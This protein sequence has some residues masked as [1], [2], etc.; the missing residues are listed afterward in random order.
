MAL[1]VYVK[2]NIFYLVDTL[3]NNK[4]YE[5]HAKDA[6]VKRETTTATDFRFKNIEDWS[7]GKVVAFADIQ[8]ES[9]A[10][11]ADLATFVTFYEENTGKSSPGA[12]GGSELQIYEKIFWVDSAN[13]TFWSAISSSSVGE[14]YASTTGIDK[15]LSN[16]TMTQTNIRFLRHAGVATANQ[17]IV[18]MDFML[19][20]GGDD[21]SGISVIKANFSNNHL[22]LDSVEVLYESNVVIPGTSQLSLSAEDFTETNILEGE[23]IYVFFASETL[24]NIQPCSYRLK[25]SIN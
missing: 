11:Y 18:K 3:D 17:T 24:N 20:V 4:I 19:G 5:A 12:A 21:I 23:V 8:D 22:I 1:K 25:C 2:T 16:A 9:G 10:A 13:V 6:I 14:E 15:S 7:P